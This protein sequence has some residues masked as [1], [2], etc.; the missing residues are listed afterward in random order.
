MLSTAKHLSGRVDQGRAGPQVGRAQGQFANRPCCA[1]AQN[2]RVGQDAGVPFVR[3][4]LV[5][6]SV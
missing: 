2:D 3:F 5:T 1:V 6:P 4:M